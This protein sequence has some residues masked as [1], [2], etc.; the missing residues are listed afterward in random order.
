M[1][2]FQKE[3]HPSSAAGGGGGGGGELLQIPT[4]GFKSLMGIDVLQIT[5]GMNALQK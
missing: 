5:I 4:L 2:L 3:P 1:L